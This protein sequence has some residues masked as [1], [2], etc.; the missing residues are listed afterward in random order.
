MGHTSIRFWIRQQCQFLSAFVCVG[1]AGNG[2]SKFG[3]K[4]PWPEPFSVQAITLGALLHPC[5]FTYVE[6]MCGK[7]RVF[8]VSED[9]GGNRSLNPSR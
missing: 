9:S 4:S 8:L 6:G 7:C 1:T 2:L 3:G 5:L